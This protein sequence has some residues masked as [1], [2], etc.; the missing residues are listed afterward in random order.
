MSDEQV[1]YS[2]FDTIIEHLLQ[3]LLR[4]Y[5]G[6]IYKYVE[7][8]PNLISNVTGFLIQPE[9]IIFYFSKTHLAIEYIGSERIEELPTNSSTFDVFIRDYTKSDNSFL[10]DIVGFKYDSTSGI[11][12]LPLLPLSIDLV[13]PTNKG[14]D[15]LMELKWNFYAQDM[16]F[17]M[18]TPA[19][20]VPKNQFARIVNGLFFDANSNGLVTRHIKWI[21]FIPLEYDDSDS[22]FD[23]IGVNVIHYYSQLVE[24]DANFTYPLPDDYKYKKLPKINRFIEL[25]GKN[26][27]HETDITNFLVQ[28]ENKF[29]L[30]MHFGAKNIFGELLCKWQ[31]EKK[32]DIKPDFFILQANGYAN[33]LEFKLPNLKSNAIVGK[34]NREIFSAEIHSYISQTRVYETFFDD[35]N[36]RQWFEN[37]YGFKVYKPKRILVAGRRIDF[38]RDEFR[39]IQADFRN[40]ELFNFD[41]LIDGV[42]AQFYL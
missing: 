16:I 23:K 10:E 35:P 4:N 8:N 11:Q 42:V 9:K 2:S 13:L 17:A 3:D 24:N 37:E 18:N 15:K 20:V 30:T 38:E 36:N 19:P 26:D 12:G 6:K 31:S 14:F 28:D 1:A 33:I 34:S 27:I 41:D 21:D 5:W 39:E 7:E 25:I 29:I 40:I 32:K 22:E